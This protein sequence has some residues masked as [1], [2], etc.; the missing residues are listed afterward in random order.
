MSDSDK[1]V[2]G[3]VIG[4]LIVSP[5]VAGYFGLPMLFIGAPFVVLFGAMALFWIAEQLLRK[6]ASLRRRWSR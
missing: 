6:L 2:A 3:L 5:F 1:T 4:W